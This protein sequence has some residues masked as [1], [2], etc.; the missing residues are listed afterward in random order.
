MQLNHILSEC[1][2]VRSTVS[3]HVDSVIGPGTD[4][5]AGYTDPQTAPFATISSSHCWGCD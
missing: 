1:H 2:E 5:N 3:K 4:I